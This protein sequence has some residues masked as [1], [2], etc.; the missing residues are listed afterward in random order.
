MFY[1]FLISC[2]VHYKMVNEPLILVKV[3]KK[4]IRTQPLYN[5]KSGKLESI[6]LLPAKLRHFKTYI[7][8]IIA[9]LT[10]KFT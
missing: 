9:Q 1:R 6:Y 3:I 7:L 2:T 4:L 8:K 10:V 5:I